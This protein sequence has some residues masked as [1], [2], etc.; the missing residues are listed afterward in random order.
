MHVIVSIDIILLSYVS[1]FY[2]SIIKKAVMEL[3]SYY[4]NGLL[5]LCLC[6]SLTSASPPKSLKF[7][8]VV[9]NFFLSEN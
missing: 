8:S 5:V 2:T 3:F 9:C 7:V 1:E 4:F 6:L